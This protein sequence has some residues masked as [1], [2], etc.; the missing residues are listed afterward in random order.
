MN[1]VFPVTKSAMRYPAP[2]PM[3]KPCRGDIEAGQAADVRDDGNT[4]GRLVD[5]TCPALC[6]RH[7]AKRRKAPNEVPFPLVEN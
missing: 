5:D 7:A 6:D 4:V 2:G 3:P 1:G